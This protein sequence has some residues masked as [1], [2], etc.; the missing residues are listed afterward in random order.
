MSLL[1]YSPI[2]HWPLSGSVA[3]DIAP[4]LLFRAGDVD[5]EARVLREVASYGKQIG[6]LSELV[7]K[8]ADAM[9][10]DALDAGGRKTLQELRCMVEDIQRIKD[11]QHPLPGT[12]DEAR[13][14]QA[15]LK[16]RF[17]NL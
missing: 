3:Q 11:E 4:A 5:T 9:P 13:E 8:L 7:L 15:A 17:K 6:K 10:A 2:V 16:K 12:V 14:L 1:N